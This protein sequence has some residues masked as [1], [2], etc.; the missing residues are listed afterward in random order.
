MK[1]VISIFLTAVMLLLELPMSAFA[2]G[3]DEEVPVSELQAGENTLSQYNSALTPLEDTE[4][5]ELQNTL[6]YITW[7]GT[8]DTELSGEGTAELPYLITSGAELMGFA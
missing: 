1:R 7:D 5:I 6:P 3:T 8:V 4:I 2:L